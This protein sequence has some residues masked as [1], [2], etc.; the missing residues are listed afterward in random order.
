MT[1]FHISLILCI[2]KWKPSKLHICCG[3]AEIYTYS[4]LS[5]RWQ[6][7]AAMFSL[8]PSKLEKN[9]NL[10]NP[11]LTANKQYGTGLQLTGDQSLLSVMHFQALSLSEGTSQH[12]SGRDSSHTVALSFFICKCAPWLIQLIKDD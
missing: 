7:C 10:S 3:S 2:F 12:V 9:Y 11:I 5:Q 6:Y 8:S 1:D 4:L